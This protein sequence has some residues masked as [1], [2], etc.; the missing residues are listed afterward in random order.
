MKAKILT[1][2]AAVAV[3]T[4]GLVLPAQSEFPRMR[5]VEEAKQEPKEPPKTPY[6][7]LPSPQMPGKPEDAFNAARHLEEVLNGWLAQGYRFAG[8]ND[9]WIVLEH[10]TVSEVRRRVVLPTN[11]GAP[12]GQAPGPP[13]PGPVPSR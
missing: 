9:H 5:Q 10:S 4:A 7:V 11:G 13:G 8:M 6:R 3:V 12:G 1:A 2:S